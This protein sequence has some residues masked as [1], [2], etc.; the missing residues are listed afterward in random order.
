M[1]LEG[2]RSPMRK[3]IL[4]KL[5]LIIKKL[6]LN[7]QNLSLCGL[8]YFFTVVL[9]GENSREGRIFDPWFCFRPY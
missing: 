7:V 3:R 5:N 9:M 8:D 2:E 4:L 1:I 6:T